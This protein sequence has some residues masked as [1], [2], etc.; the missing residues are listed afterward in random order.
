MI[1]NEKKYFTDEVEIQKR[2]ELKKLFGDWK[3][4]ISKKPPITFEDNGEDYATT[5]YFHIDGFFPRYFSAKHKVLFIG[6]EARY[7]YED[8]ILAT[9]NYFEET[10]PTKHKFWRN[11]FYLNYGIQHDGKVDFGDVPSAD[12]ILANKDFCFA[13]ANISKYNNDS[14]NGATANVS[15]INRFLEDSELKKR[16]FLREEIEL[17]E[18]DVIITANLWNEKISSENLGLV[19]PPEDFDEGT[20]AKNDSAIL[21]NFKFNGRTIPQ[22]DT[23]HFSA[24]TK[25][26][27]EDFYTPVMKLLSESNFF[28]K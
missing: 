15:L 11:L 20:P 28:S 1:I 16:N 8:Y 5:E 14:E 23:F 22:I 6:R 7:I 18:P 17:L 13:L 25:K 9:L 27:D 24:R 3:K 10:S 12:E 2:A 19:F 26:E 4:V 21:Y